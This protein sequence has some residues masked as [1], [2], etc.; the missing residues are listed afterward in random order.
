[1]FQM[2]FVLKLYS[3]SIHGFNLLFKKWIKIQVD[4]T[5]VSNLEHFR[6]KNTKPSESLILL[7]LME[8][9]ELKFFWPSPGGICFFKKNSD[10]Y[11]KTRA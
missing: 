7:L 2:M 1:M 10:V 5:F 8:S 6:K 9:G 4:H 3:K 11:T